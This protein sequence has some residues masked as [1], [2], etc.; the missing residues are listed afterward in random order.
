METRRDGDGPS[1]RGEDRSKTDTREQGSTSRSRGK[2]PVERT[3]RS[4]DSKVPWV[5]SDE[6]VLNDGTRQERHT[7]SEDSHT[8]KSHLWKTVYVSPRNVF[9]KQKRSGEF[10]ILDVFQILD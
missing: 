6:R 1:E 5:T 10:R 4:R 8:L 7:D 2:G 3:L 9:Q